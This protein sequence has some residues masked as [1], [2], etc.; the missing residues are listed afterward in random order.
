MKSLIRVTKMKIICLKQHKQRHNLKGMTFYRRRTRSWSPPPAAAAA[1]L[2]HLRRSSAFLRHLPIARFAASEPT[3]VYSGWSS[4]AEPIFFGSCWCSKHSARGFSTDDRITNG[5]RGYRQTELKPSTS[6]KDNDAVIDRIQKSTR[7]LKQGP[8]GHTLSSAEKRKFLINTLLDLEDSKEAVYSTLD[9]WIAFEQ[10]FPLAS[11]KQAIVALEK[12]EQW[13]RIVQVI[14]WMLSKGQGNTIKTYEQLVR[15]LEKDNRAEEAHKIWE[16]KIAHDLHS[17]PWCFCGLMLAIYYR[18][19]MFDRLVKLFLN[20]E[21]CG[22]KF[23]SKEYIR[24]V[25]VAYEMLGRLEEKNSLLEKYKDLS[26]KPSYSDRKKARQFKKAEK[27]SAAGTKQCEEET[28]EGVSV[29]TCPSDKEPA[30]SS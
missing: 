17:V 7:G 4:H 11:L 29:N 20:L 30:G 27:K 5:R 22:R 19:N 26:N 23:P 16:K 13:H 15:A 9:A 10:D 28:S 21:A 24:K 14:K 3:A 6:V 25:E 18:N 1:M 2:G 12:E 8:V